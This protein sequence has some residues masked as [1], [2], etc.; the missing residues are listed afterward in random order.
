M[1]WWIFVLLIIAILIIK[2]LFDHKNQQID[3]AK[4]GGMKHKYSKLIDNFLEEDG[5]ELA[6]VDNSSVTIVKSN[7][8][9]PE[10]ILLLQTFGNITVQWKMES[11]EFGKHKLEWTFNEFG[12]QD[13]MYN[14]V[15]EEISVYLENVISNFI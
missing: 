13:K 9:G 7:I 11:K 14:K 6:G 2:F 8:M 5:F 1:K 10:V 15:T 4:Q 12:D 3:V